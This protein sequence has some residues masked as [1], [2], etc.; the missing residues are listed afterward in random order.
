MS[1]ESL[2]KKFDSL[3]PYISDKAVRYS[4][5]NGDPRSLKVKMVDGN[6]F[7]FTYPQNG[8]YTLVAER[9][10][11]SEDKENGKID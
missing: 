3:F 8:H 11:E 7:I 6:T 5:V 9:F 2:W 1:P 4:S 10:G